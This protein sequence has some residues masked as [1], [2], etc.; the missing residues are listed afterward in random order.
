MGQGR[1]T[2][3][4]HEALEIYHILRACC[5]EAMESI[6][7]DPGKFA[8]KVAEKTGKTAGA[9]GYS[10]ESFQHFFDKSL[11]P[12]LDEVCFIDLVRVFEKTVFE[13]VN[14]ASGEI[15][16]AIKKGSKEKYPF[17]LCADKFVK[18]SEQDIHNLGD[19][20]KILEDKISPDLHK[21]LTNIVKYRNWLAH[22][23]RFKKEGEPNLPGDLREIHEILEE[24]LAEIRPA[25]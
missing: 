25:P 13:F 2:R 15:K 9:A 24:V 23:N 6:K 4:L 5:I 7:R 16:S 19:V 22:G 11:A 12:I 17:Y 8:R 21:E 3:E 20:Q 14:N 18:V 1:K 10:R